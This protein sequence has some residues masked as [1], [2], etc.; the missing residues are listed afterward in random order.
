MRFLIGGA[1]NTG[2]SYLLYLALNRVLPY[3]W[4]YMLS[5]AAGIVFAYWFHAK[6]VF[7]VPLS[8]RRLF[9]F[10]LV[11]VVQYL[12]SALLLEGLV[13]GAGMSEML[14]PLCVATVMLPITFV[15]SKL[16]LTW[17]RRLP[18]E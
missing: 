13:S 16:V 17:K 7:V 9:S 6:F 15:M 4:A 12:G 8:W 3:Q 1:I 11:Y 18:C 2:F 5:Y 10:P 14:A